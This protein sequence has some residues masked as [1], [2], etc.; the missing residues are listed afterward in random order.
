MVTVPP[1][2]VVVLLLLVPLVCGVVVGV[3]VACCV[4]DVVD[5]H[6]AVSGNVTLLATSVA[7]LDASFAFVGSFSFAFVVGSF[8][9][10]HSSKGHSLADFALSSFVAEGVVVVAITFSFVI[11]FAFVAFVVAVLAFVFAFALSFVLAFVDG[12][13][14]HW[15]LSSSKV[16][17]YC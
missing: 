7:S 14:V 17:C 13:D 9:A 11:S 10:A 4:A 16:C 5:C 6:L 2:V 15:S 1:C 3:V 12:A 8:V